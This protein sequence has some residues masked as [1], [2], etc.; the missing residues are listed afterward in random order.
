[1]INFIYK[2]SYV[3][4]LVYNDPQTIKNQMKI[5]YITK[6]HKNEDLET[7]NLMKFVIH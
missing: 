7:T 4:N 1:M 6:F 2:I 3:Y 5:I